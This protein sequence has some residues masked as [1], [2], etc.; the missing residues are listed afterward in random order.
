MEDKN[1]IIKFEKV[2]DYILNDK[3]VP[4]NLKVKMI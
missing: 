2:L 3:G 4:K 1:Q